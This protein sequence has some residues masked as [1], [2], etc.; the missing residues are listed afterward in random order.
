MFS[1]MKKEE[2]ME[3][4]LPGIFQVKEVTKNI[5][6][7]VPGD[8]WGPNAKLLLQFDIYFWRNIQIFWPNCYI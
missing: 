1:R 6:F 7:E 2:Y 3:S 4:E 5:A 8:P